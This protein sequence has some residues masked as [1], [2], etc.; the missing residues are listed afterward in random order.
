MSSRISV[1]AVAAGGLLLVALPRAWGADPA[2]P[3]W[4]LQAPSLGLEGQVASARAGFHLRTADGWSLIGDAVRWD[5]ASGE[6]FATGRIALT[7]PTT[8]GE[9]SSPGLRLEASHLGLIR[10]PVGAQDP[11]IAERGE[12]WDV[13]VFLR[14]GQRLMRL[15]CA[16][17]VLTRDAIVLHGL[18]GDGGHGGVLG[19]RAGRLTIGLRDQVAEDRQGFERHVADLTVTH[20]RPTAAGIPVFYTPWL[21]RDFTR[22]YPWTRYEFGASSRLGSYGRAWTRFD[23]PEIAGWRG[24]QL[25]RVDHYTESGTPLGARSE[26]WHPTIGEGQFLYYGFDLDQEAVY[27]DQDQ[28]RPLTEANNRVFDAEQRVRWTGGAAYARYTDLPEPDPGFPQDDRFRNDY[29][30]DDVAHRPLARRAI[31]AAQTWPALSLVADT[32]RAAINAEDDLDRLYGLQLTV[33]RWRIAGPAY[34]EAEGW[35][36]GLEAADGEDAA[37]RFRYRA[38]LGAERW[39][40]FGLR[41]GAE[42]GAEGLAYLDPESGGT[43]YD[44]QQRSVPTADLELAYQ[45]IGRFSDDLQHRL[46]PL[47]ALRLRGDGHGDEL[48]AWGFDDGDELVEDLRELELGLTTDVSRQRV[49]FR[50]TASSYWGLRD[51]DLPA[52]RSEADDVG[53]HLRALDFDFTGS[54]IA[55][56]ALDGRGAWDGETRDW[57]RF[58]GDLRWTAHHRLILTGRATWRE[59]TERWQYGPGVTVVGDR[60]RLSARAVFDEDADDFRTI[61]LGLSRRFV[62]GVLDL[63]YEL[64][65][66]ED[67]AELEQRLSLSFSIDTFSLY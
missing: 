21:Y 20:L 5:M 14:M 66:A 45:L 58:D 60:Y 50:F 22:D 67:G 24:R 53:Q 16:R 61:G 26:W 15:R 65:R 3:G 63:G 59:E 56:L 29:L 62:D 11:A 9:L 39:F 25:L 17:A 1:G 54:P 13:Q 27:R 36:E 52:G 30:E 7:I 44:D 34:L 37:D 32:D 46:V 64:Q 51:D 19:L 4:T 38:A 47:V 23:V 55:T 57:Q 40:G 6:L 31:A 2:P 33:P 28:D 43:Q 49:L 42:V 12:A 35:G 8:D 48:D 18:S 41:L 10:P